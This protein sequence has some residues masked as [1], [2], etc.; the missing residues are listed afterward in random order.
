MDILYLSFSFN[1]FL[2]S[3]FDFFIEI[4][5]YEINKEVAVRFECSF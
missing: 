1:V 5:A 4:I 2:S 3:L